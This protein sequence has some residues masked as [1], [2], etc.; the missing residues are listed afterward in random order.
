MPSGVFFDKYILSLAA[1]AVPVPAIRPGIKRE[2][3]KTTLDFSGSAVKKG[4]MGSVDTNELLNRCVV[5]SIAR[6]TSFMHN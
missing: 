6:P 5:F 1:L 3:R 4:D 2:T